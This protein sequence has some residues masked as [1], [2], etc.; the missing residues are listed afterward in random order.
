MYLGLQGQ[1]KPICCA[2][3][4]S[5]T[6]CR[7][8]LK[9]KG[10]IN[11]PPSSSQG[12]ELRLSGSTPDQLGLATWR[13]RVGYVA[14]YPPPLHGTP[15]ETYFSAQARVCY[16][17]WVFRCRNS[18]TTGLAHH[19]ITTAARCAARAQQGG[20]SCPYFRPW[21]GTDSA[22]PPLEPA[23][24]CCCCTCLF[25]TVTHIHVQTLTHLLYRNLKHGLC[26]WRSCCACVLI[27]CC[28]TT[29]QPA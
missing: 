20:P 14:P 28:W 24:G 29:Q 9:R 27:L 21:I 17:T 16:N 1:A 18:V 12:G 26:T 22:Q 11:C 5:W 15:S 25:M 2:A 7:W 19:C 13:A 3:W 10:C 23:A 6:P 4:H 8:D